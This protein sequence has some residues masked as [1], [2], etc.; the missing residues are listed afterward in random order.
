MGTVLAPCYYGTWWF[1]MVI[2]KPCR[3]I[4]NWSAQWASR[5]HTSL[6]EIRFNIISNYVVMLLLWPTRRGSCSRRAAVSRGSCVCDG[7]DVGRVASPTSPPHSHWC[8]SCDSRKAA[9]IGLGTR[10]IPGFCRNCTGPRTTRRWSEN[11]TYS[12]V[13]VDYSSVGYIPL[14]LRRTHR[15]IKRFF[16]KIYNQRRAHARGKL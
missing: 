14:F 13:H 2:T 15:R 11:V 9:R 10:A 8:A 3:L 16:T 7:S 4:L 1:T 5:F 6:P 12:H